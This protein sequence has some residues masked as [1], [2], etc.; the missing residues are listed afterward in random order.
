MVRALRPE[1]GPAV[2]SA[3]ALR[4]DDMFGLHPS[5]AQLHRWYE[6]RELLVVRRGQPVPGAIAL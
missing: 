6:Q 3:P 5:L 1:A 2:T 4:L